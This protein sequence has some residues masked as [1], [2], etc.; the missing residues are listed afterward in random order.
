MNPSR[1]L[2]DGVLKYKTLH[3]EKRRGTRPTTILYNDQ[4][5]LAGL[6]DGRPGVSLWS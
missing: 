1:A 3:A 2:L 4:E 6:H 5:L